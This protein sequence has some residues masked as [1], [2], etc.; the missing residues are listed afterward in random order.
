MI[1]L[2]VAQLAQWAEVSY[3]VTRCEVNWD[4]LTERIGSGSN[5]PSDYRELVR[6]FGG[7]S[8]DHHIWIY[9]PRGDDGPYD[10]ASGVAEREDA[11]PVL[12]NAGEDMPE[13][14]D[15]RGDKLIVWAVT[16]D[17]EYIYAC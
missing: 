3:P 8:F 11:L 17:G 5:L 4:D 16:G 7:G 6:N 10:L 13:W 2:S 14:F 15:A 12:W 9:A 1:E